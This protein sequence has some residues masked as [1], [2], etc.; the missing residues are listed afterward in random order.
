MTKKFFIEIFKLSPST[1]GV[2]KQDQSLIAHYERHYLGFIRSGVPP[3]HAGLENGGAF[4]CTCHFMFV[5]ATSIGRDVKSV[6]YE[7]YFWLP[8]NC[9]FL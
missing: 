9:L 4:L 1:P 5:D 7:S 8:K 3:I 2:F 6:F